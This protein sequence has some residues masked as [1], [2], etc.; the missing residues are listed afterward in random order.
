MRIRRLSQCTEFIAGDLTRLR[1][2]LHPDR[3]YPFGGRYSLAY[4][5]VQPGGKSRRHRLKTDEVY[6]ILSGYGLMHVDDETAEVKPGEAVEI[7]PN[8]VQW[9]ENLGPNDLVF[10]CIVDPAWRAE[11]EEAL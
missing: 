11:D 5:V 2:L 3:D 4:A 10:L 6:Y 7:P 8:S 9:I 1:E